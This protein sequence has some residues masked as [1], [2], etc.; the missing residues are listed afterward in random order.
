[1][2][3]GGDAKDVVVDRLRRTLT[4]RQGAKTSGEVEGQSVTWVMSLSERHASL[5]AAEGE[6]GGLT[7]FVQ[8]ADA[9]LLAR[10]AISAAERRGWS[11]ELDA[12]S[13][14]G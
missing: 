11:R 13:L 4:E 10:V 12:F 3:L 7:V 2:E 8:A 14:S 1:M 5:Y 9:R 6:E